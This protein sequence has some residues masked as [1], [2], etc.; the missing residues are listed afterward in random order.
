MA[1]IVVVVA[2]STEVCVRVLTSFFQHC[3]SLVS[4]LV[5]DSRALFPLVFFT[6][7]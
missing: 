6:K 1:I 3:S 2:G 5:F 7:W 4:Q